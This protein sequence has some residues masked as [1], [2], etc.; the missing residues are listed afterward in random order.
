[1]PDFFV[2]GVIV[3]RS[4]RRRVGAADEFVQWVRVGVDAVLQQ[5][6]EEHAAG[7]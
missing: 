1:M 5:A 4:G 2:R 3:N 6:V 7:G